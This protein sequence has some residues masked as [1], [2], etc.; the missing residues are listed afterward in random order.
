MNKWNSNFRLEHPNRKNGTTFLE[1][2]LERPKKSCS[3]YSPTTIS[4]NF[5]EWKTPKITI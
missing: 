5:G 3:I 4:G 1:A 2:P